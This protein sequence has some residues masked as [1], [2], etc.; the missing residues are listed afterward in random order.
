MPNTPPDSSFTPRK[1]FIRDQRTA[2]AFSLLAISGSSF[3]RLYS[4]P[5]VLITSLRRLFDQRSLTAGF[6]ED[7]PQNLYEFTLEGKPWSSPKSIHSERLLVDILAVIYQHGYSFLSTIDYGRENDDRLAVAFSRPTS[8]SSPRSASPMPAS[9]L[10]NSSGTNLSNQQGDRAVKKIPFA[11]SFPSATLLRVIGPP[12]H[13]TPAILQAVRGSWP[14]GVVSEKKIGEASYEFKLKGYKWFQEDT[15]AND[16]LRHIL[17]LLSSLDTHAFTLLTSLSLTNR[18]RVK[19]LWIF[20]GLVP[21]DQDTSISDSSN[22]S[23][24]NVAMIKAGH[25]TR[26]EP[27]GYVGQVPQHKRRPSA[28]AAGTT[29]QQNQPYPYTQ[30]PQG[31]M[32]VRAATD[33]TGLAHVVHSIPGGVLRKPAPRAQVPVSVNF[34]GPEMEPSPDQEQFRAVLPSVVSSDAENMTGVGAVARGSAVPTHTPGILYTTPEQDYMSAGLPPSPGGPMGA[35]RIPPSPVRRSPAR[36]VSTRSKTPP[37]LTTVSRPSSPAS[38]HNLSPPSA[39]PQVNQPTSGQTSTPPLL[40]AGVFA[41]DV[42]RDSALSSITSGTDASQEIPIK[43]TGGFDP[44]ATSSVGKVDVPE[45]SKLKHMSME[46]QLP[47]AWSTSPD[48]EKTE[49][50]ATVG[51]AVDIITETDAD[52]DSATGQ[53][54][55]LTQGRTPEPLHDVDARVASPELVSNTDDGMR[56]SEAG[57]IGMMG[58]MPPAQKMGKEPEPQSPV[59]RGGDGT[60]WVL[61]NVEGKTRPEGEGDRPTMHSQ[62]TSKTLKAADLATPKGQPAT[63]L[64]SVAKSIAIIDAK[65]AKQA[66]GKG[67]AK[68]GVSI[69]R[70]SGLRRLLSFSKRG[71][72]SDSPA[73]GSTVPLGDGVGEQHRERKSSRTALRDRLKRKGV[74]EASSADG[75]RL[76]IT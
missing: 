29:Y 72:I 44:E 42:I 17:T 34:D 69:A 65:N 11:L 57:L 61:V 70:S 35:A 27:H 21:F 38:P 39:K 56:H 12:L 1:E 3:I 26:P 52:A 73:T 62:D 60:G 49:A 5:N 23:S 4:F 22:I 33:H 47:G 20:T 68:D 7:V 74:P 75:K 54:R 41:G 28:P 36:P 71:E 53:T 8:S 55:T 31:T 66:K 16:S 13:S 48:E 43:W 67:K 51:I 45:G 6:R 30:Q 10:S 18:S 76:S 2:N 59:K 15:F 58:P 24:S 14:R 64:S 32:H 46:P 9:P 25:S 19:D 50:A 37:P 40:G 63:T